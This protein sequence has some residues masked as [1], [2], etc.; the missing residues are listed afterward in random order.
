MARYAEMVGVTDRK[1]EIKELFA[2]STLAGEV[3]MIDRA[4]LSFNPMI[5]PYVDWRVK[6]V[7]IV[8]PAQAGI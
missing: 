1:L 2:E 3:R 7:S 6:F 4:T 8:I 5:C